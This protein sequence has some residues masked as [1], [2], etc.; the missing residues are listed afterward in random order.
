MLLPSPFFSL[1]L[2][3]VFNLITHT[4]STPVHSPLSN[5]GSNPGTWHT[6]PPIPIYPR[7]EHSTVYIYPYIYIL[8][9][10]IA[11]PSNS[12]TD[13]FPT[14]TLVQRYSL[15][16]Q[17]WSSAAD[18]PIPLKHINAAA[19]NGRIYV[20]GGLSPSNKIWIA[21]R[22]TFAYDPVTDSWARHNDIPSGLEVGGATVTV[23]GNTMYLAGGL[24]WLDLSQSFQP[25]VDLF[26]AW[27][28]GT[29]V[30][31]PL[32]VLPAPRDHAGVGWVAST[33][34]LYVL[35]GRAFG[36]D[37]V[38]NTTFLFSFQT[39][40]WREVA[41]MPTA[42]GGVASAMIDNLIFVM[43]GEGNPDP[44]SHG[45]FS[46]NEAYDTNTD[47]WREYAEMD[48]PRHGT[49]AVA[50]GNMIYVPGGGIAEGGAPTS[51]FSYFED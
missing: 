18:L 12:T 45:V 44:N 36:H 32:P 19:I 27:N 41:K 29:Q 50:I 3:L 16:T 14:T 9:G 5:R 17:T 21:S 46:Q 34:A 39:L 31:K 37:N 4:I 10:V 48:V 30:F 40:T 28:V 11:S 26:T 43:G 51:Y 35:G 47:T 22:A 6:L 20:F 24:K 13:S 42:R 49:S 8:G 23:I 1:V 25:T 15:F 33:G 2:A 38:V 7:Q